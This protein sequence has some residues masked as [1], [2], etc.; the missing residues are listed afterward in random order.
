MRVDVRNAH[1]PGLLALTSIGVT[2]PVG[3]GLRP[4]DWSVSLSGGVAAPAIP[5]DD[6]RPNPRAFALETPREAVARPDAATAGTE[7]PLEARAVI[8]L[9]VG[10]AHQRRQP[11]TGDITERTSLLFA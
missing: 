10:A 11:R 2:P 6:T 7:V 8:V 5:A 1:G 9:E 4:S 3:T